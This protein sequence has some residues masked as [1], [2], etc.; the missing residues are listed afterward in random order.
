[1]DDGFGSF[2]N[3]TRV[4]LVNMQ[5][6]LNLNQYIYS[7]FNYTLSQINPYESEIGFNAATTGL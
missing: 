1:M 7:G 6:T 3:I 4:R 2:S 5:P